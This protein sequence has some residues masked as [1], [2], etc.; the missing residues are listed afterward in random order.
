MKKAKEPQIPQERHETLRRE[1]IETL[2]GHA[3]SAKEI[4]AIVGIREKDV[5]G[6]LEHIQRSMHNYGR[7]LLITPAECKMCGFIF[8][9]RKRFNKPGKCPVCRSESIAEPLFSIK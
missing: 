1:I 9:K 7:I 8:R 3:V 4:S 6:H 2:Q 5:D